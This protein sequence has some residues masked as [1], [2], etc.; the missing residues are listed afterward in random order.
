MDART[1][2]HKSKITKVC[3]RAPPSRVAT[4]AEHWYPMAAVASRPFDPSS[5]HVGRIVD[6][7]VRE[8]GESEPELS[9][10]SGSVR[11]PPPADDART[12]PSAEPAP[13]EA[14]ATTSALDDAVPQPVPPVATGPELR[15]TTMRERLLE[16]AAAAPR[17]VTP[18]GPAPA[19][20]DDLDHIGRHATESA[21]LAEPPPRAPGSPLVP[22]RSS[23][24]PTVFAL[25]GS[26]MGMAVIASVTA[27]AMHIAPHRDAPVQVA[28]HTPAPQVAPAAPAP[29]ARPKPKKRERQRLPGPFRISEKADDPGLRLIQGKVGT[30]AF[31]KAMEAAGVPLRETYRVVTAFQGIRSFDRCNK[32]DRFLVLLD[33]QTQ[34]LR[35]FEYLVTAEEVY[36]ARE[37]ANGLLEASKLDLK[38]ERGQIAGALVYDGKSFDDS[39]EQAGFERG[40]GRAVQKALD[41]HS[42]LDEL[43]RG[44]VVR[45]IAQEVT[46]L[47]EFARYAGVEAL[48]VKRAKGDSMRIFYFDAPGERGYYDAKGRSPHSGGWR[49]P[50]PG[51]P[52]T[53]RF[54]LKRLHPILKKTVPHLG[55]DFGA[56]TGAPVG[57]SAPGTV[58]FIGY[59]GPAGN[60]VKLEHP[61]GIE[62]GYAH[63]SRF[64]EG[65][66]VGDKVKRLQLIGYVGSTGR[67]TGPHLHFSASKKGE[68]FDAE[69]L[70]LDGMRTLGGG[71]RVAFEAVMAKYNPL[72]DAIALPDPLPEETPLIEPSEAARAASPTPSGAAPAPT[73]KHPLEL[74][75]E[76]ATTPPPPPLPA[77]PASG[78]PKRAGSS[79]YLTDEELLKLQGHTDDGEVK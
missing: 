72:L 43:E 9:L 69:K 20:R 50:I 40:L 36:Q 33:R 25:F 26:L 64:A 68:F 8:D 57:A 29:P 55:T 17:N 28:S 59:S 54:N 18:R 46:V 44:D 32:S 13:A 14:P 7:M 19:A 58:I 62:T 49:N 75:D 73:L 79:I 61:G 45:L 31:L 76:E 10:E 4:T 35:G 23:L 27:V 1:N 38:V 51:A 42:S 78:S 74:D 6:P 65:L 70:D 39:A 67:S 5:R 12:N 11:V 47:G 16:R 71:A 3:Q 34:R 24:S 21:S 56:P 53:S 22:A 66:K 15:G 30:E 2:V 48:E 37:G 63:L 41:G 52:I 77:P 60:L